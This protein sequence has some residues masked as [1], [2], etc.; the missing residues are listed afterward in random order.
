MDH[1]GPHLGHHGYHVELAFL[2]HQG[3]QE[4]HAP[5]DSVEGMWGFLGP[6]G[7]PELYM[8]S[9][10]SGKEGITKAIQRGRY[11]KAIG[12]LDKTKPEKKALQ[13][14]VEKCA[15]AGVEKASVTYLKDTISP[16]TLEG[17]S[18]KDVH[19]ECHE[20]MPIISSIMAGSMNG[21]RKRYVSC[22]EVHY[23][24][25]Q[26]INISTFINLWNFNKAN[27][28]DLIAA[29]GLVILLGLHQWCHAFS[30]C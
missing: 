14:V 8:S 18:L 19:K 7:E 2:A 1:L 27:L 16:E 29:T 6:Q 11:E 10:K 9:T 4:R 26:C 15:K 21:N 5:R 13:S 22:L 30:T 3:L 20:E 23:C 25:D 24:I 17:L 28:R 12:L